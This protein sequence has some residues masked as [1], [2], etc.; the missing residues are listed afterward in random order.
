MLFCGGGSLDQ[1]KHAEV[2]MGEEKRQRWTDDAKPQINFIFMG[3]A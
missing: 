1:R 2:E 3:I